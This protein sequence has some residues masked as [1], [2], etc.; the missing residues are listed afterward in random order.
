MSG[1]AQC[2]TISDL[3]A[4]CCAGL[5]L[6]SIADP[7]PVVFFEA[8]MLYRTVVEDVPTGSYTIPL[9][10]ARIARS[11]GDMTLV[12]WG[13]QVA[14]LERAVS[15]Y[16]SPT[17]ADPPCLQPHLWH[18]CMS[19]PHLSLFQ[20]LLTENFRFITTNIL[21]KQSFLGTTSRKLE[22]LERR[23]FFLH[24]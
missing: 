18:T 15:F 5:L 2:T 17:H 16:H 14:V 22:D 8:K 1:A 12:G 4:P 6:A 7:D 24:I 9:G 3:I 13:Q 23:P 21:L 10:Q 20:L 19:G 11:G